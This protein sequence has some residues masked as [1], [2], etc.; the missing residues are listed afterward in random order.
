MGPDCAGA[1]LSNF[2]ASQSTCKPP[3]RNCVVSAG[4][5]RDTEGQAAGERQEPR[6]RTG[7]P[8]EA[9]G[10]GYKVMLDPSP[11]AHLSHLQRKDEGV[12]TAL[13]N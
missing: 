4:G 2:A 8:A 13:D 6:L 12:K 7:G 9:S 11:L 5:D 1:T 10:I 3:L